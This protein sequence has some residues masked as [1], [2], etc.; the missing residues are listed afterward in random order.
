MQNQDTD[1]SS[2]FS[3]ETIAS[4]IQRL[5]AVSNPTSKDELRALDS[6][7]SEIEKQLDAVAATGLTSSREDVEAAKKKAQQRLDQLRK[8]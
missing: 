3:K 7:F 6:L 8:S 2:A 1:K 5:E 4:L